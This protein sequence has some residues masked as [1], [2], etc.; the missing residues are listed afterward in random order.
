[1]NQHS[2]NSGS[3]FIRGEF[4]LKATDD[5]NSHSQHVKDHVNHF[6]SEDKPGI[7][8]ITRSAF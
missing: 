3:E 7:A 5:Q 8:N 1:V 2:L 4:S 6:S